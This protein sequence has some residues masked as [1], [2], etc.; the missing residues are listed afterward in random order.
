M[1]T[2]AA[3]SQSLPPVAGSEGGH[4]KYY[5]NEQRTDFTIHPAPLPSF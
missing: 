5:T 1:A 2:F 3:L 4:F